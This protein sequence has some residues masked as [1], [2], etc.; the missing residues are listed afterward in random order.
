[1]IV[2]RS[3]KHRFAFQLRVG[4]FDL[5][6]TLRPVKGRIWLAMWAFKLTGSSIGLKSRDWACL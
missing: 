5:P 4:A 3:V 1:M 2:V 6:T